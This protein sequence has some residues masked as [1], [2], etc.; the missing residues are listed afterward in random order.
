MLQVL[1]RRARQGCLPLLAA[2]SSHLAILSLAY[3][4]TLAVISRP[5]RTVSLLLPPI[6]PLV[7]TSRLSS[8]SAASRPSPFA[9]QPLVAAS[10]FVPSFIC[11]RPPAALHRRP[12]RSIRWLL[13]FSPLVGGWAL[14]ERKQRRAGVGQEVGEPRSR[15]PRRLASRQTS[16]VVR[17]RP[18]LTS[19]M[20]S[21]ERAS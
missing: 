5:T 10:F 20:L 1:G 19:G 2:S 14:I 16:A 17:R 8:R 15:R 4:P 13:V 18:R 11:A 3:P 21:C 6:S 9:L 12:P 7:S